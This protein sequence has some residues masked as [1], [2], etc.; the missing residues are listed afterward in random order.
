MRTSPTCK[1][2]FLALGNAWLLATHTTGGRDL[3]EVGALL[4]GRDGQRQGSREGVGGKG[5]WKGRGAWGG[6]PGGAEGEAGGKLQGGGGRL[7]GPGRGGMPAIAWWDR[8]KT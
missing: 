1:L 4:G 8:M 6:G 7:G 3:R 5:K 2:E